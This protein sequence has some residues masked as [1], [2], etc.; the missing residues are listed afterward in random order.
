MN[1]KRKYVLLALV[2]LIIVWIGNILYYQNHILKE[3]LIIKKY[4]EINQRIPSF[5]LNYIGNTNHENDIESISFP[6]IEPAYVNIE[7]IMFNNNRFYRLNRIRVNINIDPNG[8]IPEELKNKVLTK[9][10]L[11]LTN[12]KKMDVNI[13]RIY[14]FNDDTSFSK[15]EA[16]GLES[17]SLHT[18]SRTFFSSEDLKIYGVSS[19]FPELMDGPLY[20]YVNNVPL[21]EVKFPISVNK[22]ESVKVAYK[23]GF[24]EEDIRRYYSYDFQFYLII[25]NKA[26]E[27]ETRSVNVSYWLQ[28]P[29]EYDIPL[30]LRERGDN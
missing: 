15:L 21:K 14:L 9:A 28:T 8:S 5:Y 19:L 23:I 10:R 20:I 1:I 4:C 29:E 13:G 7:R 3:P 16:N 24:D 27:K 17:S 12:G 6:E 18:G 22:D 25:E 26:G 30:L 2:F 11:N